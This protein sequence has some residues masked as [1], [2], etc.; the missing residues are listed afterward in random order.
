M[1]IHI[2]FKK[3]YG[4]IIFIVLTTLISGS[5]TGCTSNDSAS[6]GEKESLSGNSTSDYWPTEGWKT[7]TPE[8]Q[9]MDSAQMAAMFDT[10]KTFNYDV[11]HVQ[12]IRNGYTVAE[13]HYGPYEAEDSHIVY[14][15][16]KSVT[17]ALIGKAIEEGYIK[18]VDDKVLNYFPNHTIQN[19]SDY[20]SAMT[21]KDLLTMRTGF[22]WLEN[23]D[24]SN[25]NNST[26]L[27]HRS[28][29]PIQYMLDL[30]VVEAP[31]K[32]FNYSTG[33]THLLSGILTAATQK[34][35]EAYAKEKLWEPLG[36]TSAYWGKD[37]Q[38]INEGGSR[39]FYT[40][41]DLAKIGYLFLNNGNWDGQQV[42]SKEW[43]KES[44]TIQVETPKGP[45]GYGGY[46]YQWWKN[47]YDG[48]SARGYGGQFLF[49]LP[50]TNLVV[51]FMGN[52]NSSYFKPESMVKEYLIP[53]CVSETALKENPESQ[54]LLSDLIAE[55]EKPEAAMPVP[56]VPEIVSYAK[57]K[58]F[59]A[60][61]DG[62]VAIDFEKGKETA[63]LHWFVDGF[64]YDV[65]VGL[66]NLYRF[67]DCQD[68]FLKDKMSQVGFRGT[69]SD[70]KTFEIE[71]LA[72]EAERRYTLTLEFSEEGITSEFE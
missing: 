66:D 1:N 2:K 36:I 18:S 28:E 29:N 26:A 12:V 56:E 35:A 65:P 49:V 67:S 57:G 47:P 7:S 52:F 45:A 14:S 42:L 31:G 25:P 54:K 46:G 11:H 24:Y 70:K 30:P 8:A 58:V 34:S 10:I 13:C 32:T 44:T 17:S 59:D 63:T 41:G 72:K 21:I 3:H 60:E 55:E 48:Y 39:S 53:A 51:V 43:V 40:S 19:V 62:K 37:N 69:W 64:Q 23:G 61:K 15:I 5:L 50:E 4:I 20:K 33:A 22:D 71:I 16:T 68:F 9:G 38:N 27:F 6:K